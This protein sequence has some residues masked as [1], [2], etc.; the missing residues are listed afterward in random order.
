M[1]LSGLWHGASWNYVLWGFIHAVILTAGKQARKFK[2]TGKVPLSIRRIFVFILIIFT[3]IFFRS[4]NA[5]DAFMFIERIF[6]TG[7][8]TPQMPFYM[9]GLIAA[10]YTIQWL[11]EYR[12]L[13]FSVKPLFRGASI[14][15]ML[16]YIIIFVTY[17]SAEFIY[18]QF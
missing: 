13:E 11:K 2:I 15:F 12:M 7:F 5:G 1:L 9:A 10:C 17:S 14:L 8:K 18:F 6:T 4:E 16:A 3:W